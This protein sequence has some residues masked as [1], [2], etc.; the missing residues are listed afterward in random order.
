MKQQE[1]KTLLENKNFRNNQNYV[2]DYKNKKKILY[3]AFSYNNKKY[4]IKNLNTNIFKKYLLKKGE[5]WYIDNSKIQIGFF[6]NFLYFIFLFYLAIIWIIFYSV[7]FNKL[8]LF[9][10]VIDKEILNYIYIYLWMMIL[11][12][13]YDLYK[14]KIQK[15][16]N[17][18]LFKEKSNK[19]IIFRYK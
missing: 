10:N 16:S 11:Y 15:N 18:I 13:L 17:F 9:I 3:Y 12:F 19:I 6:Y 2:I 7:D 4:N 8:R 1:I 5:S 14:K